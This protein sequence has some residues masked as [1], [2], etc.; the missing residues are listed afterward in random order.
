MMKH[1]SLHKHYQITSLPKDTL[2]FSF[3]LLC[4]FASLIVSMRQLLMNTLKNKKNKFRYAK[5]RS[6]LLKFTERNGSVTTRR[7]NN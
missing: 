6:L 1:A 4:F 7:I 3:F 2:H 5:H